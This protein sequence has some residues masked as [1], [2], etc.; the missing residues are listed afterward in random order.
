MHIFGLNKRF[1][2]KKT[3]TVSYCFKNVQTH[4]H[5]K[6][7]YINSGF[8][9]EIFLNLQNYLDSLKITLKKFIS[10]LRKI[11]IFCTLKLIFCQF[12]VLKNVMENVIVMQ[13]ATH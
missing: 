9:F 11:C 2:D 6:S 13:N 5:E 10:Y 7:F 12:F 4:M 8:L 1:F 3:N